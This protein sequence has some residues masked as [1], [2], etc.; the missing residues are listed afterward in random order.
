LILGFAGLASFVLVEWEIAKAPMI[1][2]RIFANRSTTVSYIGA[3][4][5]GLALW[6]FTYYLNIFLMLLLSNYLLIS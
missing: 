4:V 1:P 6:A 2:L 3:F 5:H